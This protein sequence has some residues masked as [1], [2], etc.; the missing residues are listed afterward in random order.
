MKNPFT[1]LTST[2]KARTPAGDLYRDEGEDTEPSWVESERQ[3]FSEFRD[4]DGD[5]FMDKEEVGC[6]CVTPNATL[7]RGEFLPISQ[8]YF[9]LFS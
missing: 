1:R 5:S 9:Q 4:K 6:C 7:Y 2:P 3:Q 8:F